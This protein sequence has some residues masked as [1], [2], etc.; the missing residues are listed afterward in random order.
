MAYM[1]SVV[2]NCHSHILSLKLE[3][4]YEPH[5]DKIDLIRK[6]FKMQKA[7]PD[8]AQRMRHIRCMKFTQKLFEM[9]DR[10]LPHRRAF[11]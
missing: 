1:K 8:R 2:D 6:M 10:H 4:V 5:E 3:K 7:K 9:F 11:N